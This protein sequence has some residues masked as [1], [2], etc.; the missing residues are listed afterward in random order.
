VALAFS[1]I[2]IRGYLFEWKCTGLPK[3]TLWDWLQ[4]LIILAVLAG[5]GLWFN[6]NTTSQLAN[7]YHNMYLAHCPIRPIC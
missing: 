3:R 1:I 5:G 7:G 4:L 6:L 2:V